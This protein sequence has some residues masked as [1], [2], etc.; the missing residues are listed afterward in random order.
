[1]RPESLTLYLDAGLRALKL[2]EYAYVPLQE[3]SLQ[4][5]KRAD[6]RHAVNRAERAGL[7]FA[8]VPVHEVPAVLPELR[9]ISDAWLA[10]SRA[11][12]KG[13]SLGTFRDDYLL[14]RPVAIVRQRDTIVAFANVMCTQQQGEALAVLCLAALLPGG[15]GSVRGRA[16]LGAR[17]DE[18]GP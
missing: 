6:L 4:G 10:E 17:A 7:S 15:P 14:R 12:E 5:S 9:A 11:R 18:A 2:G 1:V 8:V 3:F 16:S 13:F